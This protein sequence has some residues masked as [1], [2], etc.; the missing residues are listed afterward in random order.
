[1]KREELLVNSIRF[2]SAYAIEKANSGHPGLPLGAAPM[3]YTLWGRHLNIN[4]KDP[5]W[6]NRDRFILSAGHGSMLNYALLHLYGFDLTIDDIKNFRQIDSKTPGHP[7]YRWTEGIEATTGPLGQ[8]ISTAVGIALAEEY[9]REKYNKK[10]LNLIDHYTYAICGDGDLMEGVGYEALSLAGT[11]GLSKL[12]I[13]YDS[14]NITIDGGTDISFNE[15]IKK[16]FKGFDFQYLEVEDGN[17]IDAID[18]TIKEAKKDT[19]RPTLIEIKTIIGYGAKSLEGTSKVH[20]APLGD[21]GLSELKDFFKW[22]YE[23]FEVPEKAYELANEELDKKKKV[24]DKWLEIENKYKE[25]YPEEYKSFMDGINGVVPEDLYNEDFFKFEKDLATREASSICLN[26]IAEKLDYFIGGSADLAS[27]NKTE[28]KSSYSFSKDDRTGKNIRYGIR[29]FAMSAIGNGILL[30]GGLKTF[31]STFLVFSD[32]LK[33]GMRLSSI[34]ELPLIYVFTHDSIGVGEDGPTHQPIEQLTMMRAQPNLNIIRPCDAVETAYAWKIA[35]E[36]DRTPT[37]FALSRQTL[38]ILEGS[39]EGLL[40]G[41]YIISEAKNREKIDLILLSSGSEVQFAISAKEKLEAD[42]IS[43]RVVSMPCMEIF[44]SQ[45][46]E[47]KESVLP[48]DIR[49]RISLEAAS[50][51]PW[52]KYVGLDGVSI[53]LDRFGMSGPADS[54]FENLNI[55]EAAIIKAA[56]DILDLE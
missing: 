49:N 30:H 38:P 36:S 20:G 4:P 5:N 48:K 16:R 12:I 53:G 56:K 46:D 21:Q 6:I 23:P 25:E 33:A 45:D 52:G 50:D 17:D 41:G 35:M 13:L 19:K 2:L 32:Y 37:A 15:D 39:G 24:Y 51:I 27:S 42:G 7:E 10:D 31:V 29:E 26:T 44:D 8:G 22:D 40:R 28:I 3:A 11:L 47:Y 1:M 9:L 18:K 14:N 43:T 54:V 55:G 34:M